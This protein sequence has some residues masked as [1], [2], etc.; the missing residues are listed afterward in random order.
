MRRS[1]T[2][3]GRSA[4]TCTPTACCQPT[5]RSWRQPRRL[6]RRCCWPPPTGSWSPSP[7]TATGGRCCGCSFPGRTPDLPRRLG[8]ARPADRAAADR[9][10][11]GHDLCPDAAAG[12]PRVRVDLPHRVAVERAATSGHRVALALDWGVNTLLTGALGRLADTGRVITDGRRLRYDATTMSAKLH[13][14][15]GQREC[16]AAKREHYTALAAGLPDTDLRGRQLSALADRAGVE[17]ERV[18]ARIRHLNKSLAWSAGRWAVDQ[19]FAL[20]TTVVYLEDLSSLQARGRRK[21]NARLSGQVRGQVAAAIVH[22][23]AKAGLAVVTVPA[24]GTSRYCPAAGP[25]AAN[26]RT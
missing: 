10:R 6:P 17:H 13:R 5:C 7:A 24:R 12:P 25:G 9:A 21:G 19:A 14:L 8:L 18:C 2:G 23:A 1:A 22:L 26:S 20:E 3:P 15:R 11:P 4:P 16:L